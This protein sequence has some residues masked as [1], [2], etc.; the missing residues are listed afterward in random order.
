MAE[1]HDTL[2]R[3]LA[4]RIPPFRT[5]G[6]ADAVQVGGEAAPFHEATRVWIVTPGEPLERFAVPTASH[7]VAEGHDTALRALGT[8]LRSLGTFG[9]AF[10]TIGPAAAVQTVPFHDRDEGL[11]DAAVIHSVDVEADG[12]ARVRRKTR[13]ALED[14]GPRWMFSTFGP[15]AA[16]QE[17]GEAAPFHERDEGLLDAVAAH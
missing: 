16:V 9:P 7:K 14:I 1:A 3:L 15:A 17:G 8:T 5:F 12:L 2:L 11:L 4:R 10:R 6:P 13:H